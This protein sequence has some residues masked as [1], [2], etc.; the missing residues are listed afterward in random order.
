MG[1]Q[2]DDYNR[3]KPSILAKIAEMSK[4]KGPRQ[5]YRELNKEDSFDG[6]RDFKQCQNV[7]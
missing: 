4:V 6:P 5:I 1:M 2:Q 7:K 3:S